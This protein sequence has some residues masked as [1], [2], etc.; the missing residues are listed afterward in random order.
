[1]SALRSAVEWKKL[2]LSI[3]VVLE[4]RGR[5]REEELER[6]LRLETAVTEALKLQQTGAHV[7]VTCCVPDT[8]SD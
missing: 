8:G 4:Q 6:G 3:T 2:S 1:M 5:R 7:R